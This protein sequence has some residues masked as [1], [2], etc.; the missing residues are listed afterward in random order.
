MRRNTLKHADLHQFQVVGLSENFTLIWG[1][2]YRMVDRRASQRSMSCSILIGENLDYSG[3]SETTMHDAV[4]GVKPGEY[5]VA[6]GSTAGDSNAE[7]S[8]G[9]PRF[10]GAP[11]G[12]RVG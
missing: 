8:D 10:D 12:C 2:A 1:T 6:I 3:L 5:P 4:K 7:K 9:V 11:V